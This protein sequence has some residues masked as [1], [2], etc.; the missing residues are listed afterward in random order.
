MGVATL[1]ELVADARRRGRAVGAFTCL[2]L[3][4]ATA[5]VTVAGELRA[6]V[7]VAF[8][9]RHSSWVDLPALAAAARSLA[10]RAPVPVALHLDHADD[11]DTIR[12]ALQC[13]FTSVMVGDAAGPGGEPREFVRAAV[14]LARQ[15]GATVEA[16]LTPIPQKESLGGAPP[17]SLTDPDEAA[18][19]ARL[20]GVDVLAVAVGNV[21]HQD[22]GEA[23]LDL[24]RLRALAAAVPCALSLHGGSGVADPLLR[25]AIAAGIGKVSF[26]TR[27]ARSALAALGERVAAGADLPELLRTLRRAY[28]EAVRER[29][30]AL[31]EG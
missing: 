27:L 20:T 18:R 25:D 26:F 4:T 17:A 30:R 11:L 15:Y 23:R 1:A 22:P 14:A 2:N 6:P 19:F 24:P 3:E 10:E 21:H 13:G 5:I 16:E 31:T 28:E 9:A 29:L 12:L 7:A 8:T